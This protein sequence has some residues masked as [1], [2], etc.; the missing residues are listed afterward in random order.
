MDA[1][2]FMSYHRTD[3]NEMEDIKEELKNKGYNMFSVK[4]TYKFDGKRHNDIFSMI[5]MRLK[6]CNVMVYLVGQESYSRPHCE[7][8]LRLALKGNAQRRKGIVAI[9]LE[10]R[11][12][13]IA[14]LDKN[15]TS[16]R[17]YE[18]ESYIVLTTKNEFLKNPKKYIDKSV[19]RK[20]NLDVSIVNNQEVPKFRK[21]LYYDQN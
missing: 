8:E 21:G 18:N 6:S 2:I 7:H 3:T 16:S 17:I 9:L 20:L 19:L 1:N 13:N 14:S 11:K 15:I 10:S 5:G 4:T 12:D